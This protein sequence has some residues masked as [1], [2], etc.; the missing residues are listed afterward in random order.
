[1]S[2]NWSEYIFPALL[3]GAVVA[4]KDVYS[5]MILPEDPIF[6]IDVVTNIASYITADL[7]VQYAINKNIKSQYMKD[8]MEVFVEPTIHGLLNG[9]ITT[10]VHTFSIESQLANFQQSHLNNFKTNFV[11]GFVN[12]IVSQHLASPLVEA[13]AKK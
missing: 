5:L 4:V 10:N 1:M 7:L 3:V 6:W 12:H 8:N 11:D 9:I 2:Y 13:I